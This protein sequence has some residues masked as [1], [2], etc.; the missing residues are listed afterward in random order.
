MGLFEVVHLSLEVCV[1]ARKTVDEYQRRLA[2]PRA[3]YATGNPSKEEGILS[4]PGAY[5]DPRDAR[6]R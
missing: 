1:A 4:T 6:R 3:S 2:A 5:A